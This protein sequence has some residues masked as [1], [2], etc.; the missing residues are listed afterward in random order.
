MAKSQKK[1]Y[2]HLKASE[3]YGTGVHMQDLEEEIRPREKAL[4]NPESVKI[5][6]PS[7]L[8]AI[9]IRTGT[10]NANALELSAE[11]MREH[12]DSLLRLYRSLLN[13]TVYRFKGIGDTKRVSILAALELG[14][15]LREE[16]DRPD[17]EEPFVFNQSIKAYRFMRKKFLGE[18]EEQMWVLILNT[19]C[20]LIKPFLIAKGGISETTADIRTILRH[21]IR[22]S[23]AGFI[24]LHNH[25]GGSLKPS[26]GDDELTALLRDASKTVMITFLDHIILTDKGYYSYRDSSSIL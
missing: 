3:E 19:Q 23:G 18:S 7:E 16:L 25:P 15:R 14:L 1:Y 2:D 4:G 22:F 20:R 8:I 26:K 11:L 24:L 12:D 9:I 13:D 5:L 10:K 17:E 21:V 6:S